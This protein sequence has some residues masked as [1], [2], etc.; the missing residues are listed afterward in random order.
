MLL[1]FYIS[2]KTFKKIKFFEKSVD[3]KGR[4]WYTNIVV[5]RERQRPL[6]TEQDEP[7]CRAL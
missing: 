5:A 6:K 4:S 7:M 1:I 3:S 2:K